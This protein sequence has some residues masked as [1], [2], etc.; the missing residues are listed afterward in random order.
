MVSEP[1]Q[2][3]SE[4]LGVRFNG[5]N[6]SLWEFSFR[7]FVEGKGLYSY[8]D[9]STPA[10]TVSVSKTSELLAWKINNAK[11]LSYIINSVDPAIALTLRAFSSAAEIWTHLR[12]T[13]SQ[14]NVSRLFDL[15]FAISNLVQ[16]DLDING[17]YLAAT[18]L[19]T[20][21]D[22]LNMS[23]LSSAAS[24]EIQKERK[25][26]R[27]L[28]FL[29]K[30]RPEYETIRSQ[31]IAENKTDLNV[32]IGDLI[33]FETR[34]RT[35]AQLDSATAGGHT[36]TAFAASR[37][38]PQF[39]PS[40]PNQNSAHHGSY[41]Q[42][43]LTPST[44]TGEV[45][46]R[47]CN[48]IGHPISLC[49][50]RNMCNYCKKSGHIISDCR[51]RMSKNSQAKGS[52]SG[53]AVQTNYP[54]PPSSIHSLSAGSTM[55]SDSTID[56]MVQAALQRV[57]PQALNAAFA[58]VGISGTPSSTP[59]F[60]DS[61]SFNHMTGNAGLFTTYSPISNRHIE[62]ANGQHLPIAGIGRIETPTITLPNTLH[63]PRLVP[64]LVSV[65]QLIDDGCVVAF[66][67]NGCQ[68]QD[69]QTKEVMGTG[70]KVGCNFYLD[71]LAAASSS[72]DSVKDGSSFVFSAQ[73]DSS[74]IWRLWH[75][76]LG[77]PHKDRL[78]YMFSKQLLPNKF[79]VGKFVVPDCKHCIGAKTTA[80]PFSSST[81]SVSAPFDLIHT[82]LWG[83]SPVTS[84]NGYR[85]YALFV[86][87]YTRYTWIFFLRAK[88]ELY[89][90]L[91]DFV[92]MIKTQFNTTI[93]TFRSDP[94][95]EYTS[96]ALYEFYKSQGILYQHSCPGVS[97]QNG[98]VER[99]HRHI[100]DLARAILLQSSVPSTFW[101]EAVNTVVYLINRQPTRVLKNLTPY[102]CLFRRRPDY[103]RL[104]VFGCTCFVLLPKKDRSKLMSK[105]VQCVFLG[106]TD[107]HKGY[108]CYDARQRRL[109]TAYHVVFLE[110]SY[111]YP[112]PNQPPT[113]IHEVQFPHFEDNQMVSDLDAIPIQDSTAP[114]ITP[115]DDVTSDNL[116]T[117]HLNSPS[118]TATTSAPSLAPAEPPTVAPRR[119][120]RQNQ[121]QP[122]PRYTDYVTYATSAVAIP[123]SYKEACLDPRWN[124]AM[125]EENQ[126]L[127]DNGTWTI[128]PRPD[129]ATVIGSRWVYT[130][131][132][133]PDGT[134]DRYKARLVAQGYRQ[135]YGIDYDETF[136]PV[137][138][139]QT[140]R[141]LLALAAQKV[142]PLY[143]LDVKNAFLHGQLK[144]TVYMECPPGY[145]QASE[146]MVCLLNRSLYG[147]KQAPRAWFETFQTLILDSGFQQS[148]NDPS[149][150]T[151]TTT[152]GITI[153]LI[154]VDD[155]ILTGS[156]EDGIS[157]IR[158]IL[159]SQFQV[160]ELGEL[161]YF[162]GLQIH[163]SAQG[164]LVNQAK[165]V[166][167]LLNLA[168]MADARPAPTPI[169]LNL[170][171]SKDDGELLSDPT[172]YR[173][174]VGSLIYLNSTRPDVAYAVQIVSQFMAHPRAPHMNAVTRI[175]RY[176][177]GTRDLGI[178]FPSIGSTS[179]T[180]FADADYAG[181]V[182]TR[183]STSGWCVRFG[184]A[185][186]SWR[187]K[188]QERVSKSSTEAEYR[189]MSDVC[190]E[191]VWLTRLL[192]DLGVTISLPVDLF[193]D[194][195]SAIQIA[196][197]PVL[198]ERT[199]HIETHIHYI[200][201]LVNSGV[202]RLHYL[203]SE[204]QIADLLTKAVP[205]SRHWFLSGKL[206][207]RTHHQ[208]E[209]GC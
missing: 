136:A 83:P 21:L 145:N 173:K 170:K 146:G 23:T 121:G 50:K 123:S 6:Y 71:H 191:I 183:R 35:Q 78:Q 184:S 99:K 106:Y 150:F 81:T 205:S 108:L 55:S 155:M 197:N 148:S 182:D 120:S 51:K 134:I 70:S 95:G 29:M 18:H 166:T 165:Y 177:C 65:G 135:E 68:V 49:R 3:F 87:Q 91:R 41:S 64:N 84:R 140:V 169:E 45:R 107:H 138:K 174:L 109:Y 38:R 44:T 195:T 80:L 199:K 206:M 162:L 9:G 82:D 114:I 126:A 154:Y 129:D 131:K 171:L 39:V 101:V 202:V 26:T 149:L 15:E 12:H 30:L 187:C 20:E 14:V 28:Q 118:S 119:S 178:F 188:K 10:P 66:G 47:F 92:Q 72:Q 98:L 100:L 122:P 144:E 88:S 143:Q 167:D 105:T 60:I 128:V 22:L 40:H 73:L 67:P 193:G 75:A 58:T 192:S 139:M 102:E 1:S 156:D 147:L 31:I 133:K 175:L 159:S 63:V 69:R 25:R 179:L 16:G 57:L 186:V 5:T 59:W 132:F 207:M 19:W 130:I 110:N 2:A 74:T 61:A 111:Y 115:H 209:G 85:Y 125:K 17:Y 117:S 141:M 24:L 56:S 77:H 172:S 137:A 90:V 86:D 4:S 94:G 190:S 164:I 180:A 89:S 153:L 96:Q 103:S 43:Q 157:D 46:C 104:R 181:C 163:R 161:S 11:V 168:H 189:S 33:R 93:K 124:Q 151:K 52:S 13:Y 194:N 48:E 142:W 204:D 53:Y 32:I 42:S 196:T 37:P 79:D 208:F 185:F 62:V 203:S 7:T 116:P 112:L 76:R 113:S 152:R 97:E 176:L 8:L 160:K 158:K 127:I 54:P 200:R 198:H 27:T 34:L 201:D 36:A